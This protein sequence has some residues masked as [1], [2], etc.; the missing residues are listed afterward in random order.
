M[1]LRMGDILPEKA[2]RG[3]GAPASYVAEIPSPRLGAGPRRHRGCWWFQEKEEFPMPHLTRE[4][5]P[6]DLNNADGMAARPLSETPRQ[7]LAKA[8]Q[9]DDPV[10]EQQIMDM[11]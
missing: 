2:I 9:D 8:S 11:L 1:R 7:P 6:D 4:Q 5:Q 10:T 3:E